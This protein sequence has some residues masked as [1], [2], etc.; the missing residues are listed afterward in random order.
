MYIYNLSSRSLPTNNEQRDSDFEERTKAER[1]DALRVR[2]KKKKREKRNK[3]KGEGCAEGG[4]ATL[5]WLVD[6]KT[7]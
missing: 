5:G 2:T 6:D 7:A 3:K 1:L 4:D